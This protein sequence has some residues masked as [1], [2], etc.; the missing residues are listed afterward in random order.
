MQQQ[1]LGPSDNCFIKN[2]NAKYTNGLT[3]KSSQ[4]LVSNERI[5][6]LHTFPCCP[7]LYSLSRYKE[8]DISS[9][10]FKFINREC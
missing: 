7:A 6:D 10:A 5:P 8:R 4:I 3:K 9:F 1:V 2:K